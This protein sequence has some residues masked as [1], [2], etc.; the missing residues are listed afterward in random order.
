MRFRAAKTIGMVTAATLI[1][2]AG[3]AAGRYTSDPFATRSFPGSGLFTSAG[4]QDGG[5]RSGA[6]EQPRQGPPVPR[7]G[8]YLGAWVEPDGIETDDSRVSAVTSFERQV[9]RQLDIVHTYHSWTDEFPSESDIRFAR[10][11]SILL[12]SWAGADTRMITSGSHDDLIRRRA[13]AIKALGVP[14]FLQWRWEMDRPNLQASVWS[15]ADFVAAWR[16]MR[17]I[18]AEVGA[19]NAGWVWCPTAFGFARDRAQPFYPGDSHV[20][21]L[22]ANAA[23]GDGHRP[24]KEVLG[25]FL[26]WAKQH[27]KPI[28]IAEFGAPVGAPGERATWLQEAGVMAKDKPQI[29][30]LVYYDAESEQEGRKWSYSLRGSPDDLAAYGRLLSD[31]YFDPRGLRDR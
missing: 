21:W 15:P 23:V 3:Y 8:A 14:V 29:K 19:D 12:L 16:H 11:G 5:G 2:A 6:L 9:G 30:A 28:M 31:S 20:E 25:P 17:R 7:W 24:L 1:A 18:F 26:Q 27:P 4:Q 22:C 10:R 13:Q